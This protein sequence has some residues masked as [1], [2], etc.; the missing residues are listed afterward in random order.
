[1]RFVCKAAW[2]AIAVSGFACG[3]APPPPPA[4]PPPTTAPA[5]V[6]AAPDLSEV[7]EPKHLIGI[8]RWKNPEVTLKTIY[9]WTGIRLNASELA[10]EALDKNLAA[11]L[12]LDGPVD[13]AVTL[14]ERG[15]DALTPFFAV[16]VGVRSVEAAKAAAQGL[17]TVTEIGAGEY[18]V[19]LRG[20][21][22]KSDKPFCVLSAAVGGSPGRFVCGQHERDVEALRAYMTRTLPKRDF[23]ASDLHI[24]LRM[25]PIVNVYGPAIHHGLHLAAAL[26]P[27]KLQIG[28]P[29]FDRA[30]DRLTSGLTEEL[31]TVVQDLDSLTIDLGM[32]PEKATTSAALHFKGQESWTTNTLANLATRSAPPP[33][34]F[35]RLPA[36]STAALY[37]Y[38]PEARRFEV[39]RRLAADLLDGW[40][41]HEGVAASDRTPIGSLFADK[42]VIDSPWVMASGPFAPEP[43]PKAGSKPSVTNV[44]QR[45]LAA[46]GW[47]VVGV[48]APNAVADFLKTASSATS[49]PKI[50]AFIKSK[51]A[52]LHFD[53]DQGQGAKKWPTAFTLKSAAAP[54][55]LPK[56]SLAFELAISPRDTTDDDGGKKTAPKKGP[57]LPV[58]VHILVVS[59]AL[60]TWVATGSEKAELTK[61]LLATLESAPESGT[62]AARQELAA[63]RDG[64]FAGA[65]FTTLEAVVQSWSAPAAWVD[66]EA[67]RSTL[68][69]YSLLASSPNKGTTPILATDEIKAGDGVTW[70]VRFDVPKGVI[71]DAVL[72][73]ASS[74][75]A[76]LPRP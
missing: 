11:S 8:V 65:S 6:A 13:A 15:G 60:Q 42:F 30:I 62:L 21:K 25:A 56:G 12:A 41:L 47:H 49:R 20:K 67:S 53:E 75:L 9:A 14:D 61:A 51:L 36:S 73:A 10:S 66:A 35:W 32:A 40:L 33:P 5:V 72:L 19:N 23:G 45:A 3:G 34:M 4:A 29:S 58:K 76:S 31:G 38:L 26:G 57:P 70:T 43:P 71:E 22:R 46:E 68:A 52:S 74:G 2:L 44:W 16:S 48:A 59:E 64:K 54:K 17:G 37:H 39:I 69:A 27:S 24:E 28:E 50:Q 18:K 1:M 63:L 7:P 55:E